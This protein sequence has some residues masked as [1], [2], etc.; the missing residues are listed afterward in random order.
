[1]PYGWRC[2]PVGAAG[3]VVLPVTED[4]PLRLTLQINDSQPA[5][6]PDDHWET[7][8]EISLLSEDSPIHLATLDPGEVSDAWPQD[9][10]R[11]QMPLPSSHHGWI[12]MRLYCHADAPEPGVDDHEERHLIQLWRAPATAPVHPALSEED[13]QARAEYTASRTGPVQEY[14]IGFPQ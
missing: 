3:A 5:P 6:E 9:L 4:G 1:M 12:R 8:E 11:P 7:A 10:P 14:T 13:R 2:G